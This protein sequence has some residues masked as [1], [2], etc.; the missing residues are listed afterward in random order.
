MWV[1]SVCLIDGEPAA[2]LPLAVRS[3]FHQ[4]YKL[5]STRN[6]QEEETFAETLRHTPSLYT[7]IYLLLRSIQGLNSHSV[8]SQEAQMGILFIF[9]CLL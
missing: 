7:L 4:L 3:E 8:Y 1:Q 5:N 2:F 9:K 6:L